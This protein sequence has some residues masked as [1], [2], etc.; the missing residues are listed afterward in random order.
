MT[1]GGD[2][3]LMYFLNLHTN[4]LFP[5]ANLKGV[6]S[7]KGD[8]YCDNENNNAECQYDGGDCCP[9]RYSSAWDHFC[10]AEE[11]V[12]YKCLTTIVIRYAKIS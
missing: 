2:D 12:S 5:F 4:S 6:K 8:K 11:D 3:K 7:W 9:P 10:S 1:S